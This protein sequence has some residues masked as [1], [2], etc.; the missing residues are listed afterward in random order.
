MSEAAVEDQQQC[1]SGDKACAKDTGRAVRAEEGETEWAAGVR[2]S[3]HVL[4]VQQGSCR[5]L[6][7]GDRRREE[8]QD[9]EAGYAERLSPVM[10]GAVYGVAFSHDDPYVLRELTDLDDIDVVALEGCEKIS[11][12]GAQWHSFKVEVG[13]MTAPGLLTWVSCCDSTL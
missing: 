3:V 10:P 13:N 9:S 5:I 7:E 12:A 11:R 6:L 1:I 4:E 8:V 2:A